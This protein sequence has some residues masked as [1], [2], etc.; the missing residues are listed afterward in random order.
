MGDILH[1]WGLEKKRMLPRSPPEAR[2]HRVWNEIFAA[3]DCR[4]ESAPET[5]S[6]RRDRKSETTSHEKWPQKRPFC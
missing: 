6:P 5:I 2:P 1:D 4:A 3:G